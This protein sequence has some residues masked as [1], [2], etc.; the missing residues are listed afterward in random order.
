MKSVI[1]KDKYG[2]LLIKVKDNGDG[3]YDARL[4]DE[5]HVII[6]VVTEENE[7]VRVR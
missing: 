6:T 4:F 1:I 3:S 7:R 5:L 2:K